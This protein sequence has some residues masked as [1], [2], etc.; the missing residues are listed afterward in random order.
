VSDEE[1]TVPVRQQYGARKVLVHR[2]D[3]H[4]AGLRLEVRHAIDEGLAELEL[5]VGLGLVN[6]EV[7]E[8]GVAVGALV[9]AGVYLELGS[10]AGLWLLA[11]TA[12]LG[13]ALRR[14]R[15]PD[16]RSLTAVLSGRSGVR[17]VAVPLQVDLAL[18]TKRLNDYFMGG[19]VLEETGDDLLLLPRQLDALGHGFFTHGELV[20]V[21]GPRAVPLLVVLEDE[22]RVRGERLRVLVSSHPEPALLVLVFRDGVHLCELTIRPLQLT[23]PVT[24]LVAKLVIIGTHMSA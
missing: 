13:G 22:V 24:V 18:A 4:L 8:D 5:D 17:A 11:G 9:S 16:P 6:R 10:T 14:R 19:G 15:L 1:L 23:I 7:V 2:V 12:V 20:V 21:P 3:E